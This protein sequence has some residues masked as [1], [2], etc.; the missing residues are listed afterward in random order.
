MLS[1]FPHFIIYPNSGTLHEHHGISNHLK[2]LKL[3][4][5]LS[6][7]FRLT[8]KKT[9]TVNITAPWPCSVR[10]THQSS[11]DSFHKGSQ[12]WKVFPWH[13][14]IMWLTS[15]WTGL[16]AEMAACNWLVS[17][18]D[19][20]LQVWCTW[21]PGWRLRFPSH[22]LA[23]DCPAERGRWSPFVAMMEGYW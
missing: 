11:V 16:V 19:S 12:M 10:V 23:R 2:W 5:L 7:H 22:P 13:N 6:S 21:E 17:G 14:I 8:T 1:I 4:C 15:R 3:N 18:L 9:L 20:V